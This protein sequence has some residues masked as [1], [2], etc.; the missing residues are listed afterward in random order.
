MTLQVSCATQH[1]VYTHAV[2]QPYSVAPRAHSCWCFAA[3]YSLVQ[4]LIGLFA[5]YCAVFNVLMNVFQCSIVRYIIVFK[6]ASAVHI[7]LCGLEPARRV[8]AGIK[9]A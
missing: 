2:H 9:H 1:T 7:G 3:A 5:N 8:T 4:Q 6:T